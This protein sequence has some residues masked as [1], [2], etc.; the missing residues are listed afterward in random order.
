M[1]RIGGSS[2]LARNGNADWRPQ[3]L[4]NLNQILESS[5]P[6][7]TIAGKH[8]SLRRYP[9]ITNSKLRQMF[10][11]ALIRLSEWEWYQYEQQR[12]ERVSSEICSKLE[13]RCPSLKGNL[14]PCSTTVIA[15]DEAP[16]PIIHSH[17]EHTLSWAH[18]CTHCTPNSFNGNSRLHVPSPSRLPLYFSLLILPQS[19]ISPPPSLIY[20]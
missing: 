4:A 11:W 15:S 3:Y 12:D 19:S 14:R 10:D 2:S 8:H 13:T 9:L 1:R 16:P 17:L 20:C 5:P 7:S 6:F 18:L